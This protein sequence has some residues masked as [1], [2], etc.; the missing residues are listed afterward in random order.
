MATGKVGAR[1]SHG[2][3]LVAGETQGGRGAAGGASWAA[4]AASRA[5]ALRPGRL[6]LP[7][8]GPLPELLLALTL[9]TGVVDAIS[10]LALGRVFVANMTGNVVFAGFAIIGAP[11]FSLS[12]SVFA[13]AGFLAG[14]FLGGVLAT[15]LGA[16][17]AVHLRAATAIELALF[18]AALAIAVSCGDPVA[19][20]GTLHLAGHGGETASFGG[21]TSSAL[22]L[23]LAV[24]MGFQNSAA[25]KLAVPDLTTTVLTQ[26]LTGIGADP[27]SDKR[28]MRVLARRV[29]AVV[30]MMAGAIAGAWLVTSVATVAALTAATV[31]VALVT[32]GAAWSARHPADWRAAAQPPPSAGT[33]KR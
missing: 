29:L 32:A 16:D 31:V 7:A 17:R 21:L 24:A 10:I 2:R 4:R 18:A 27:R 15:R 25:R 30:T 28:D 5:A 13:L 20:H 26:T 33:A 6:W 19:W 9:L 14:A 22:A 3:L 12:S 23:L 8:W 1:A 11:G